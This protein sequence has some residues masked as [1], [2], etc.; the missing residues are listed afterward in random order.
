MCTE[1]QPGSHH[2]SPL[3][4]RAAGTCMHAGATCMHA[5]VRASRHA[6]QPRQSNVRQ[7][8]RI[9]H[10]REATAGPDGGGPSWA[11]LPKI[12]YTACC[13]CARRDLLPPRLPPAHCRNTPNARPRRGQSERLI[14]ILTPTSFPPLHNSHAPQAVRGPSGHPGLQ[15]PQPSLGCCPRRAPSV[16]AWRPGPRVARRQPARRP[17]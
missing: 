3:G 10:G 8:L 15:Q 16:G 7:P 4:L 13:K 5:A 2:G 11:S 9:G 1:A 17:R 14:L 6:S 12:C